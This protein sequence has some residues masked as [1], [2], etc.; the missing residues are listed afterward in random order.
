MCDCASKTATAG[1]SYFGTQFW[2]ECWAGENP[3]VAYN[4]DGQSDSCVDGHFLSCDS[5]A[6]SSCAGMEDVN[7]V[8]EIKMD[9]S[10]DGKKN[11]LT[12]NLMMINEMGNF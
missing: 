10:S 12:I 7:Y 1:Y 3:D 4:S 8:Y 11:S 2:A 5:S 6:A 9:Q